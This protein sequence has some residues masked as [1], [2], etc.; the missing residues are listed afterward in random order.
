[1]DGAADVDAVDASEEAFILDLLFGSDDAAAVCCCMVGGA[2]STRFFVKASGD[3]IEK[4]GVI[5]A[6]RGILMREVL[7]ATLN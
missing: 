6:G 5:N 2:A 3:D 4:E 7:V 1:V